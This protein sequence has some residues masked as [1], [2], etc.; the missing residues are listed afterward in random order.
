MRT[1]KDLS[2]FDERM[3]VRLVIGI[4]NEPAAIAYTD[5]RMMKD[6][7]VTYAQLLLQKGAYVELATHDVKCIDNFYRYVAVPQ[8]IGPENFEHQY[9]LGVPRARVQ[10]G[11]VSGSYF[12]ELART[13]P[14]ADGEHMERLTRR[15]AL[16]RMYL[17]FGTAQV[18]G[19]YCRRRL[20]ENP[21]MIAYG[22]KNLLHIQ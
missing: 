20:R 9:L 16:V 21:N 10:N 3:R 2:R 17:P 4:Y 14:G 5:K 13:M 6:L 12:T 19:A 1:E 7:L 18:S 8:K 15:G 22:I 11:L